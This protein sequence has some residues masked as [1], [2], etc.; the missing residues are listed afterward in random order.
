MNVVQRCAGGRPISVDS[1]RFVSGNDA[2]SVLRPGR[3]VDEKVRMH[4]D[5]RDSSRQV[6]EGLVERSEV[7]VVAFFSS[8]HVQDSRFC[9][10][11]HEPFSIDGKR[12]RR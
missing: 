5:R 2:E 11:S 1:V 7:V 3:S 10:D 12:R 8:V 9:A 6:Q 4:S